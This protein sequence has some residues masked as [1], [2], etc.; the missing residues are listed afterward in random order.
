M[1]LEPS[2]AGALLL[3]K[4]YSKYNIPTLIEDDKDGQEGED[5][6]PSLTWIIVG[7]HQPC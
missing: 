2:R 1:L 3:A 7:A 6:S 4:V 5:D